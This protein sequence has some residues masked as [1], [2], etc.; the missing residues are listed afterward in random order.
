MTGFSSFAGVVLQSDQEKLSRTIFRA[1]RGNAFTHIEDLD[2]MFPETTAMQ[3]RSVFVVYYQGG[4]GSA[5]HEKITR[6]CQAF[7]IEVFDWPKSAQA[8]EGKMKVLQ[9]V[10]DDKSKALEAFEE[11]FFDEV[12]VLLDPV[13]HDGNSLIEEWRMFCQK[14]KAIFGCL[15]LFEETDT[16]LRAECW[17]PSQDE[18][19]MRMLLSSFCGPTQVS[20]FLLSDREERKRRNPPTYIK[21]TKFSECFQNIVDTYG[22][23]RYQE[24]NPALLTIVTFP[25]LFG[26]MYGD[27]GHGGLVLLFGSYLII[28]YEKVRKMSKYPTSVF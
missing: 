15:N 4:P 16:T 25:F 14:Q 26:V 20:A 11:F 19:T 24:A 7:G 9:E 5:M 17:Y 10:I 27:I 3:K 6:I 2:E 18:E 13:R 22:V 21:T 8:A 28:S 23:P 12:S 1:T